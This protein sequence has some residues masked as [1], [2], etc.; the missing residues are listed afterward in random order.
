MWGVV[1]TGTQTQIL[2]KTVE[3]RLELRHKLR[4]KLRHELRHLWN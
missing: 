4:H 1:G 2:K 3:L